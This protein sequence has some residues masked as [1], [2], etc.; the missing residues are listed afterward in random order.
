VI[1]VI[2]SDV[3]LGSRHV[4]LD[5]LARFL[6]WLPP[7]V[8]L[9]LN[10]DTVDYRHRRPKPGHQQALD[11][12]VAESRRRRVVWLSGN[13]DPKYRPKDPGAIEFAPS[14]S[15]GKRI[16]VQHG[17]YFDNI[18][19][20]HRLF[21]AVFRLAHRVRIWLGADAVHVAQYAKK[22]KFLYQILR[23]N[24]MRNAIEYARENGYTAVTCGHTHFTED[25]VV[26]G[27]R[28]INTGSWTEL[29]AYYLWVDD[30]QMELRQFTPP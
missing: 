16:F 20:Y 3:H 19:P 27:I 24:V 30:T 17:F 14:F 7:D 22:W 4:K 6:D 8:T 10:G 26:D 25:V 9:V 21:I 13:H 28:Y 23:R 1:T 18:M 12:I 11:R 5:Q 15:I 29:P 2:I